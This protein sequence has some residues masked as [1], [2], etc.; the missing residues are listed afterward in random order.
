MEVIT[1]QSLR[2]ILENPSRSGR[3]VKWAIELS[4]FDLRYR[5]R[6]SIKYQALADFMVECTHGP[7]E[8]APELFNLVEASEQSVWLLYVDGASNPADSGAVILLW[9]L[10]GHKIEYVLRFAFTAMNNEAEYKHLPMDS[11]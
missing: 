9:S 3:I 7:E 4:E 11:H 10:E 2:Q 5:P 6:T 8:E 1:N